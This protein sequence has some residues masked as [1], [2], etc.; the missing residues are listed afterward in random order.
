MAVLAVLAGSACVSIERSSDIASRIERIVRLAGANMLRTN[1]PDLSSGESQA[2]KEWMARND[3]SLAGTKGGPFAPTERYVST[4]RNNL[5]YVHVLDWDGANNVSLPAVTDRIIEKAW[6]LNTSTQV[7]VDQ[8]P[9]GLLVVVPEEQRPDSIDTIVVLQFPSDPADLAPPR[10]VD[11]K[12]ANP[13]L[14]QGD[15]AKL[16]GGIRH[17]PGP[18]WIEG[19]E[20]P[21]AS[22]TWKVHVPS[23]GDYAVEMTYACAPECEGGV[24]EIASGHSR[25]TSTLSRT[26]GMW[27]PWQNFER[28]EIQGGLR[29]EEGINE[30]TL[31]AAKKAARGEFV[32][33]Y[34]L[35][36]LSKEARRAAAEADRRALAVR[37][38]ADWLRQARYGLMVHWMPSTM[39]RSGPGKPFCDAVRDFDVEEFAA[40]V[41]ETGAAYLIF[42]LA[43]GYQYFPAPFSSVDEVLPGRTCNDR[44]LPNE[45][46]IALADHGSKLI[47][48]YH[49]GVGDPAWSKAA[50]FLSEDKTKFFENEI[51]ILTEAGLRYRERIAGWWFDDRYPLQPFEHLNR[52]A[53]AGNSRRIVAF[54]SW[55]MPK[56]TEFQDYWA[57]EVGGE[58]RGLPAAGYFEPGGE[59]GGLQPHVLIFLDDPWVH[60][61]ADTPIEK[62]RFDTTELVEYVRTCNREGAP[63]TMNVGVY[64]DGSP[65][66]ATIAQ[67]RVLRNL[68]R[69]N[70]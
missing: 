41:K 22:V 52:A 12:P 15:T 49:H 33:I 51:A 5:V 10:V 30:I 39:P 14:L 34:G 64:Q 3:E 1:G 35:Y 53:K 6:L 25:L 40:T 45:L 36:L 11:G 69:V 16:E 70:R 38:D 20:N 18:D 55:I 58:L 26:S 59:Q 2:V 61:R 13:V 17:N 9:W 37:T 56:A 31:R 67:L 32:R 19:W 44:D 27:G 7:R 28:R 42:T 23:S 66:P 48:Y 65:S 50:G 47:L 21:S 46:A 29:L 24:L 43:H 68:I 4:Y 63:V 60:G 62:P 8:A 54:N 57:G